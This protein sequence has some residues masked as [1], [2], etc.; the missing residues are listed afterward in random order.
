M[1]FES[2]KKKAGETAR[3]VALGAMVMTATPGS[4]E[5]CIG[6]PTKPTQF[7]VGGQTITIEAGAKVGS[8]IK[9]ADGLEVT[10]LSPFKVKI[11]DKIYDLVGTARTFKP[12][13]N[14]MRAIEAK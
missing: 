9:G 12:E 11:G 10:I 7:E 5:A 8:V 14:T 2:F 4:A 6:D 1:G 3:A 13:C